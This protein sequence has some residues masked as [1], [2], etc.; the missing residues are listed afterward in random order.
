MQC[1]AWDTAELYG[2]KEEV[3]QA[4]EATVAAEAARAEAVRAATASV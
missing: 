2:L 3:I 4:R 1:L